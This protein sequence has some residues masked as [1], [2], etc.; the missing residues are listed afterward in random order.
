MHKY[1]L[2]QERKGREGGGEGGREGGRI[3]YVACHETLLGCYRET[4]W[5]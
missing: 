5:K 1:I 4:N 3:L 2:K